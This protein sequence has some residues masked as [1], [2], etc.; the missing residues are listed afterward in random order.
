[1]D[2]RG[3]VLR[4]WGPHAEA[5]GFSSVATIERIAYPSDD[6]LASLAVV[7]ATTER[8]GLLT[9]ILVEPVYVPVLLAKA[10]AT[11]DRVTG[12]RLTLGLG[13]GGR[14]DDF[15]LTGRSFSDRGK[16]LDADLEL[17]HRAWA[18]EAI[19]PSRFPV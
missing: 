2:C 10:A 16:R 15:E 13:V 19:A 3:D 14:A 8:I 18:G 17:L 6:S 1:L 7:G 9:N 11:I 5:R 12:G 4:A